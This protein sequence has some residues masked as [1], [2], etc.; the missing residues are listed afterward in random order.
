MHV[1]VW[2]VLLGATSAQYYDT[3]TGQ[4]ISQARV[5]QLRTLNMLH[6][7]AIEVKPCNPHEPRRLDY[8]CNNLKHPARGG[9]YTPYH[10]MLPPRHSAEGGMAV[11]KS[12]NDLPNARKLRIGLLT[13]ARKENKKYTHL[14]TNVALQITGD[15]TSIHD[16]INYIAI[17]QECCTPAGAQRPECIPI[18]VDEDDLYLRN[19]DV[20]CLNLTRAITYQ[21]LGCVPKSVPAERVNTV[22]PMLELSSLYGHETPAAM[23]FREMSGGRLRADSLGGKDWP[24]AFAFQPN[25]CVM[26]R[27]INE[28]RCH[29]SG[30]STT[31]ILFGGNMMFLQFYRLHNEIA[32]MLEAMNP[33]WSDDQLYFTTREIVIGISAHIIYYEWA[34]EILGYDYLVN[35]KVIFPGAL[36]VDDYDPKLEPRVSIEY[37]T[38]TRWFHVLQ[39]GRGN[40]YTKEGKLFGMIPMVDLT[41]RTGI[42]PLNN[43]I[44]GLTQGSFRQGCGYNQGTVDPD[45]SERVLTRM[46]KASDVIA[47]DI[48]KG[49]D[50][51]LPPY[52]EYRKLC[53]LPVAK[54]FKDLHQWID[55]EQVE[56]MESL[57]E[58]VDDVELMAA[59]Y[60]ERPMKGAVV[61]P[62]L[63]C[64]MTD[65]LLRWRRAD[66][67][68]YQGVVHPYAFTADQ[69]RSIQQITLA[70]LL[71]ISG[72]SVEA[73]QPQALILPG[74]GNEITDC[75]HYKDLNLEPWRDVKCQ[76]K[77]DEDLYD[78][79]SAQ[80][81]YYWL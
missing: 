71:C 17:T 43:T 49:R 10:R 5:E 70:K 44:Q 34:P 79:Y 76:K 48:M 72:D 54:S 46:Q 60:A 32:K 24:P 73:I 68:W 55:R 30:S 22:A 37:V 3:F 78:P 31:N 52:N 40:L 11:A 39:E 18:L 57:Y 13:D 77:T 36:H 66:R 9:V 62:I 2:T 1:V 58:S 14:I 50:Q 61:G 26:N 25:P 69:L 59:I 23:R 21:R 65:Q 45:M 4:P 42:L 51:G 63:A 6:T 12:G 15:V 29:D 56:T 38:G 16:S 75:K 19:T 64:I 33:C 28:T 80:N 27:P 20:R 41:L 67:Y 8:T 7:C 47:S 53:K 81:E 74:P 35:N